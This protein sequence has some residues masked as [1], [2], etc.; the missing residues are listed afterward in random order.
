MMF[1]LWSVPR[2]YSKRPIC[3]RLESVV[4][5]LQ[6]NSGSSWLAMRKSPLLA[7]AS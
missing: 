7:A 6:V 4:N 2:L 3:Q 5:E 1:S